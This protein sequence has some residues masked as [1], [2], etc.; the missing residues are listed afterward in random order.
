MSFQTQFNDTLDRLYERRTDKLRHLLTHKHGP[1]LTLTKN[2]RDS[3][4]GELK[5]IASKAFFMSA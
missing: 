1:L 5:D 3:K 2:K 4:I